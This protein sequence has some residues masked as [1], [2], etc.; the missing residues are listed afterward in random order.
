MVGV[1]LLLGFKAN[2]RTV[3]TSGRVF[4]LMVWDGLRPDFVTPQ[5]TPN[6]YR[7]EHAGADF[8]HQHAIFP[9]MTMANAAALATGTGPG[10]NGI[11]ADDMYFAP[12]LRRLGTGN[13]LMRGN[14]KLEKSRTLAAL[15]GPRA[16]DGRLL[17]LETVAQRI[18]RG[19]GYLAIIGKA[20]PTFLFDDSVAGTGG[21]AD[22]HNYLFVADDLAEPSAARLPPEQPAKLNWKNWR[23]VAARDAWFTDLVISKALPAAKAQ[24]LQGKNA[25]IVFWQHDPDLVQHAAGLGTAPALHALTA[26]DHDLARIR[27]ALKAYGVNGRTDLMVV[28]DHGFSTI[29]ANVTLA[30]LLVAAGLKQ[31]LD[32]D[33][34]VI[35]RDG[36]ADLLYLSRARF[37]TR[38][39]RHDLSQRIVNYAE[40]QPWCGPIFAKADDNHNPIAG[41]FSQR[42]LGLY[43]PARSPDLILSFRAFPNQSNRGL[44]G[45]HNPGVTLGGP[46]AS[47]HGPNQSSALVH[48]VEGVIYSDSADLTDPHQGFTTGMGMHGAAG[49]RDLHNFCAAYGPDFRRGFVDPDPSGNAD[50]AP[51][52]A[53]LMREPA[54]SGVTGRILREALADGGATH[55]TPRPLTMTSRLRLPTGTVTMQL[56]LTRYAGREYLDGSSVTRAPPTAASPPPAH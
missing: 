43:N 46:H 47:R 1:V 27:A 20:G 10:G 56:M 25:L 9:T 8:A 31:A 3:N 17:G 12:I 6:L 2:A 4:V 19:G 28:S 30:A 33:D 5:W 41:T 40:A 21:A 55:G 48:P 13:P 53:A 54:M 35:S 34:V 50:I 51:T 36:G 14:V 32:S 45:P 38:G 52:I 24:A 15:D 29:R 22:G 42:A 44:T 11:Y 49:G 18:E 37:K 23:S 39:Q 16:F 26:C 7:L